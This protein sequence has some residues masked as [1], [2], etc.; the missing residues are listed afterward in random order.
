MLSS[1]CGWMNFAKGETEMCPPTHTH[2][3]QWLAKS[4]VP[5]F[6]Q[7]KVTVCYFSWS[8]SGGSVSFGLAKSSD[9]I[10]KPDWRPPPFSTPG[11]NCG[12]I[13]RNGRLLAPAFTFMRNGESSCCPRGSRRDIDCLRIKSFHVGRCHGYEFPLNSTTMTD[14]ELCIEKEDLLRYPFCWLTKALSQR[15][16]LSACIICTV[17]RVS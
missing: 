5:N 9:S 10:K 15:E 4:S 6:Q 16:D 14:P 17:W 11:K 2:F 13:S 7:I 12:W 8:A 1:I 3:W